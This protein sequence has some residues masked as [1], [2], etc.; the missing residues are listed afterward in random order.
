MLSL[1]WHALLIVLAATIASLSIWLLITGT[2]LTVGWWIERKAE[3]RAER[4]ADRKG[5]A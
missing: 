5:G 2:M 4:Q 3:R 1:L